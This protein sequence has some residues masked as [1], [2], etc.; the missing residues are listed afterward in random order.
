MARTS[1]REWYRRHEKGLRLQGA[2]ET[3]FVTS[4]IKNI[5]SKEMEQIN[6]FLDHSEFA[7]AFSELTAILNQSS[8]QLS[9]DVYAILENI[10]ECMELR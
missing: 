6:E 9:D 8:T 3:L 5:E 7:L 1:R 2:F 4:A 10:G